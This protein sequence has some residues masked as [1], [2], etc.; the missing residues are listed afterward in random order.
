MD[1]DSAATVGPSRT[2]QSPEETASVSM[3]DHGLVTAWS[4]GARRLLGYQP[5]EVVGR[6]FAGLLA[7]PLP[8]AAASGRAAREG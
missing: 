7:G 1:R 2:G 5:V 4:T 3:D 6:A 8:A